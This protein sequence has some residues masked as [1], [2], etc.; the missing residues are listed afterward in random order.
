MKRE[1]YYTSGEFAKKTNITKKTLR[2]YDEKNILKPSCVLPTGTRLYNEEDLGKLQ[3]ILL[4]KYLG[5]SLHEIKE[6]IIDDDNLHIAK[7][8]EIQHKLVENRI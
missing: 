2:Y 7:S 3:Q 5:F 1:G 6:M 8:L 4:L